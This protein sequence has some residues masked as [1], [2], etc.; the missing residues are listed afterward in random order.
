MCHKP[1]IFIIYRSKTD[2]SA[3]YRSSPISCRTSPISDISEI[4]R[5]IYRRYIGY[6]H[7]WIYSTRYIKTWVTS[8]STSPSILF[9]VCTTQCETKPLLECF[10]RDDKSYVSSF[11]CSPFR[12]TAE[13]CPR[14]HMSMRLG[15]GSL[16]QYI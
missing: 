4:Y 13:H 6:F 7:P 12:K 5:R 2:I 8:H 16:L 9:R 14:G 3:I 10:C 15:G 1:D 11:Y